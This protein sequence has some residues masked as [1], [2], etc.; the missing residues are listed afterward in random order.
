MTLQ[1]QLAQSAQ[2][3]MLGTPHFPATITVPASANVPLL[4]DTSVQIRLPFLDVDTVMG[5]YRTLVS[6]A[7]PSIRLGILKRHRFTQ[8]G[9]QARIEASLAALN[10]PQPTV[11][12]LAQWRELI[13]EIEEED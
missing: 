9:R 2:G 3:Q 10:G 12:G 11:L 8:A 7:R 5:M 4:G 1:G 6:G 13:E